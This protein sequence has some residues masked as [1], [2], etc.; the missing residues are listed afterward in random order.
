MKQFFFVALFAAGIVRADSL[1]AILARMD[2]SSKLFKTASADIKQGEY[3]AIIKDLTE[4]YG[5][6]KIKRG[7][8]SLM[9][10]IDYT[11]PDVHT[12]LIRDKKALLYTPLA[13]TATEYDLSRYKSSVDQ[14]VLLAFGSSGEDLKKNYTLKVVG[15]EQLGSVSTTRVELTPK[16]EEVK[17]LFV[18]FE[19]WIP[20]GQS[21]AIRL[22]F[23]APSDNYY[24]VDY[25]NVKINPVIA[26]SAFELKLP[27]DVKINHP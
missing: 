3:T 12:S 20:E 4:S 6:L 22:K 9:A 1:D 26:D 23:T 2:T 10:V 25:S 17:K 16:S 18:K 24:L 5:T 27:K 14:Y 19:L 11:K 8:K 15:T 21:Y 7:P 13:K